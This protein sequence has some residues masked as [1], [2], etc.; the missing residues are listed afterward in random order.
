MVNQRQVQKYSNEMLWD[1][2]NQAVDFYR[3]HCPT[4]VEILTWL[5]LISKTNLCACLFKWKILQSVM[6][7]EI[8]IWDQHVAV[9]KQLYEVYEFPVENLWIPKGTWPLCHNANKH[10]ST[11][12]G[13]KCI[14][15]PGYWGTGAP[16]CT[17]VVVP[18]NRL[19]R[20]SAT[21]GDYR[22]QR[23]TQALM[24]NLLRL[25]LSEGNFLNNHQG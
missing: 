17:I 21:T 11:W 12:S 14:M 23:Q 9:L 20:G 18:R 25:H 16:F 8:E 2:F 1:L 7:T 10:K 5:H 15:V 3:S 22:H 13:A 4:V 6:S 19:S 24:H